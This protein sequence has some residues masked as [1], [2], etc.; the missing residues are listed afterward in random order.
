MSSLRVRTSIVADFQAG[1]VHGQG[2][3]R[4]LGLHGV[5]LGTET[6]LDTGDVVD[7][8]FRMPSGEP[9]TVRSLVWWSTRDEPSRSHRVRGV[10]LRLIEE[11]EGYEKAFDKLLR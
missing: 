10:G 7:L 1:K 6:S 4:N 11:N 2:K 8:R 3:I 9:M 5:F